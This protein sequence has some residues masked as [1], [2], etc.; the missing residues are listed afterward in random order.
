MVLESFMGAK[1]VDIANDYLLSFNSGFESSVLVAQK[2]DRNVVMQ[3]LSV[4]SGSQIITEQNLQHIA[5]IYLR[6]TI[7]LSVEEAELLKRKLSAS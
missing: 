5:E 1:L 6:S 4:M 3:L 7:G 2:A